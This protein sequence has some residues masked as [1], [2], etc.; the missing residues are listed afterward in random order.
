MKGTPGLFQEFM[1]IPGV[2]AF[3]IEPGSLGQGGFSTLFNLLSLEL[4]TA[5]L[6]RGAIWL[7]LRPKEREIAQYRLGL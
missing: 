6:P 3:P 5:N 1:S 2:M 4:I 7:W